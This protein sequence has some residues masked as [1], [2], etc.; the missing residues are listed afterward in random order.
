MASET[1]E[2]LY[3]P[4]Q[5]ARDEAGAMRRERDHWREVATALAAVIATQA[6]SAVVVGHLQRMAGQADARAAEYAGDGGLVAVAQAA[7]AHYRTAIDR[8]ERFLPAMG[9][10]A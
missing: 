6:N 9:D 2:Q 10:A 1:F 4:V 8:I 3:A 7:A 5:A